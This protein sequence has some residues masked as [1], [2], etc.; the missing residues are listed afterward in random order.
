MDRLFDLAIPLADAVNSAHSKGVAHRDLK[1]ANIMIDHEGRLKVLDFG[2]AKLFDPTI[3]QGIP[4][5]GATID[6]A[7]LPNC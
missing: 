4:A 5:D 1:P 6:L 7:K 3:G 2:L